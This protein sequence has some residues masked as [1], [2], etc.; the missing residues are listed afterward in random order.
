LFF[1]NLDPPGKT[2]TGPEKP[3]DI[4][5]GDYLCPNDKVNDS[6]NITILP[7]PPD[8][9]VQDKLLPGISKEQP[10]KPLKIFPTFLCCHQEFL[11]NDL[12]RRRAFSLECQLEMGYDLIDNLVIIYKRYD[13]H[14]ASTGGAQQRVD[15][16]HLADHVGPADE[17]FPQKQGKDLVGEDFLDNLVMETTDTVKSAIR[18][19]DEAISVGQ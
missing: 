18:G 2:V 12:R 17:L 4:L 16:I 9:Q 6:K 3:V 19:C 14:F 7:N 13:G 5:K 10:R 15:F 8:Q 1:T 11:L